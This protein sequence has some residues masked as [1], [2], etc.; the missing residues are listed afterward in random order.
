MPRRAHEAH[1]G[2]M[3]TD[4]QIALVQTSFQHVLPIAEAVGML[5]YERVFTLAPEARALFGED[6]AVQARRTMA[7]VATA[8]AGLDALDEVAPFLTRLGARHVRYG[9]RPEHFEVV[10]AALL[11]T[12]EQGLDELFTPAVRDAWIAAWGII[13]GAMNEG[14][15]QAAGELEASSLPA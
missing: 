10:G 1:R 12:L 14:M 11:W 7:A 8:V 2:G 3:I 9:V 4:E 13:A 5:F 15:R 6:I